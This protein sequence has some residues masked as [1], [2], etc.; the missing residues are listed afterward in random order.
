LRSGAY[1][2]AAMNPNLAGAGLSWMAWTWQTAAFFIVIALLLVAMAV[3][4]WRVP[5]GAPRRG[6]LRIVTT[7]GDR[8]FISLLAAAFVH[9]GWLAAF[10]TPLWGASIASLVLAVLIFRFV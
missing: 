1:E 5:G 9:L 10:G 8:L 2:D 6:V 7:R 4:E 3:W